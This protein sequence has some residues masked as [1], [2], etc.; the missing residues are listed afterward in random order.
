MIYIKS[1][2]ELRDY[3]KRLRDK[4]LEGYY[5]SYNT[6]VDNYWC[7][8][9]LSEISRAYAISESYEIWYEIKNNRKLL[10]YAITCLCI[11]ASNFDQD[12]IRGKN[13]G[14]FILNRYKDVD[15]ESYLQLIEEVF[16]NPFIASMRL[17]G[18]N[19]KKYECFNEE[20]YLSLALSNTTLKLTDNQ[21][22]FAVDMV[23]RHDKYF[24]YGDFSA[25]HYILKNPNWT[26]EEK[27]KLVYDFFKDDFL[28]NE[29]LKRWECYV[30]PFW[31]GYHYLNCADYKG[32]MFANCDY[33]FLS[34]M[35]QEV[36]EEV[37]RFLMCNSITKPNQFLINPEI[38]ELWQISHFDTSIVQL[39]PLLSSK[40]DKKEEEIR[41]V[42]L[43]FSLEYKNMI[44][45]QMKFCEMMERDIRR[46]KIDLAT[47][48][49]IAWLIN[50]DK[51][52]EAV[53]WKYLKE[54]KSVLKDATKI[55]DKSVLEY[56]Y[57]GFTNIANTTFT[58]ANR[59]RIMAPY[60]G[61][62]ILRN[63]EEVDKDIYLDFIN[64]I[65]SN[66]DIARNKLWIES[67]SIF[68][69]ASYLLMALEND[70]LKLTNEQKNYA[71]NEIK[72]CKEVHGDFSIYY[73]I[74]NKNFTLEEKQNLIFQLFDSEKEYN[75][76][77]KFVSH[78]N[79]N[80]LLEMKKIRRGNKAKVKMKKTNK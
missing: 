24:E 2:K 58:K 26:I 60:I 4:F 38:K 15:K 30:E 80:D 54:E 65:F 75:K 22:K 46:E 39:W 53:F 69:E 51:E 8:K 36:L 71:I 31:K 35:Y 13:I 28:Y 45:D 74:N 61:G 16:S 50:M 25:K 23:M 67:S 20:T 78:I 34:K 3:D 19:S 7:K 52:E 70:N 42:G 10:D 72:N 33:N 77:L 6:N 1:D 27:K 5:L 57:K 59:K 64:L 55:C 43:D 21:K 66:T 37:K 62:L 47:Y 79:S 32:F 12:Y 11:E 56:K 9:I 14:Y 49:H 40:L 17:K 68:G 48:E 41:E 76:F 18:K 29:Q 73:L 63:H 44:W